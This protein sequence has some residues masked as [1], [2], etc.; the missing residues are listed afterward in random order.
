MFGQMKIKTR[1]I[2]ILGVL[3]AGYLLLLAMV[4]LS[5]TATHSR[6]LQISSSLFPAALRMQETEASFER[7][8]K[9]YGDAVVLQDAGSLASAEKAPKLWARHSKQ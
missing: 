4:Q 6:M 3:A 2:G 7:M 5:A 1:I 8:K 9:H